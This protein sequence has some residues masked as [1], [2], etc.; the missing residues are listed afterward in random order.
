[1]KFISG[2]LQKEIELDPENMPIVFGKFD[3]N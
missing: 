3:K 2:P 1:M